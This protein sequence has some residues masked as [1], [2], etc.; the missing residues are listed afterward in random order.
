[1]HYYKYIMYIIYKQDGKPRIDLEREPC[2]IVYTPIWCALVYIVRTLE[3]QQDIP[4]KNILI[5]VLYILVYS[6][7]LPLSK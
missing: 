1:M 2:D 6:A 7:H 4:F 3:F 5:H